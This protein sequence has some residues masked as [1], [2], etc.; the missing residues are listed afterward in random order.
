MPGNICTN[1][2]QN[3]KPC[4]YVE[5]S[6]PRGPPKA[7]VTA[8]EDKV[9]Y[10]EAYLNKLRPGADFSEFLGPP[11]IRDSW[12]NEPPGRKS[13]SPHVST[14]TQSPRIRRTP[15]APILS[16]NY[17]ASSFAATFAGP[18]WASTS[19]AGQPGPPPVRRR[20]SYSVTSHSAVSRVPQ[21]SV[22]DAESI[23]SDSTTSDSECYGELDYGKEVKRLIVRDQGP[24]EAVRSPVSN[25]GGR[26]KVEGGKG[27][28]SIW[29]RFHGKSSG[30]QLVTPARKMK[31]MHLTT[32]TDQQEPE[33]PSRKS[34]ER[35][36]EFWTMPPW[37]MTFEGADVDIAR[38]EPIISANMPPPDLAEEL[39]SLYF[40]HSNSQFPL[41]H[42][43][44][45]ERLWS[46]GYHQHDA[47]FACLCFTL[48][49][50]ASRWSDD[51][52]VL[53]EVNSVTSGLS[54]PPSEEEL[55]NLRWRTAGWKYYNVAIEICMVK[56]SVLKPATLFEI[57]TFSLQAMF[58]RGND[59][60]PSSWFLIEI[61]VRKAQDKGIHRKKAYAKVPPAEGELWKRAWWLLVAFDRV[62][63]TA[64]GRPC[65]SR[66]EDSDVDLPSEVDDEYWEH[67]DPN[68]AFKQPAG[69]P[70]LVTAFNSWVRLT[71]L[72]SFAARTLYSSD[73]QQGV[74]RRL[75]PNWRSRAIEKMNAALAQWYET[76]PAH[77]RWSPTMENPIFANQAVTLYTTY[78]LARIMIYR[79]F[80]KAPDAPTG[81]QGREDPRGLEN[82]ALA[83]CTEAARACA[84]IIGVQLQ[85]GF[86][87]L[88]N[89]ISVSHICAA[90]LLMNVW[91]IKAR[92][93]RAASEA[94][95]KA[96]DIMSNPEVRGLLSDVAIFL[97]ALEFASTK[98]TMA[99]TFLTQLKSSLPAGFDYH[100]QVELPATASSSRV[101]R[102]RMFDR[103][104][105][106][107][108]SQSASG[109]RRSNS[110]RNPERVAWPGPPEGSWPMSPRAGPS[111]S[112]HSPLYL[113][114]DRP[115]IPKPEPSNEEEDLRALRAASTSN[116]SVHHQMPLQ[117]FSPQGTTHQEQ[118]VPFI[119][120]SRR[121]PSAAAVGPHIQTWQGGPAQN[122]TSYDH[123]YALTEGQY[124]PT[125][126]FTVSAVRRTDEEGM[127]DRL[128][129][130]MSGGYR[131]DESGMDPR[132]SQSHPRGGRSHWPR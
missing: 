108:W 30:L 132:P 97:R 69:K 56:R 2:T 64:L 115:R 21:D 103:S 107:T 10:L 49:A 98:W 55:P 26:P 18:D 99:Y 27:I 106:L 70:S 41:L 68:L 84:R 32:M 20:A 8:L 120:Q 48:F 40:Q 36:Q 45:F 51:D 119:S 71:Q 116:Y 25:E 80:I 37:E 123:P 94:H 3:Q 53:C 16:T 90:L 31:R 87:N 62:T 77:L 91:D 102:P 24:V 100:G 111:T 95:T 105:S 122:L 114:M 13:D 33:Q 92:Q 29:R 81:T 66:D 59:H 93:D 14:S 6:K 118:R 43:P 86:S 65:C 112:P 47:W 54:Q 82:P 88:S 124:P 73:K 39:I 131:W 4:T 17:L 7:Y 52:R 75:G 72:T 46:S 9:E 58:L 78:H 121:A 79:P 117:A 15:S 34:P 127:E 83:V 113:G 57:Q 19:A 110:R 74:L 1:C 22:S 63:S 109:D 61:G 12:K 76:I 130:F 67:P 28:P 89:L 101:G 23:F 38:F 85:R 129:Q 125:Q 126:P 35:R 42:R 104:L 128:G 50:V 96:P 11:V 44:T 5:S 60:Y